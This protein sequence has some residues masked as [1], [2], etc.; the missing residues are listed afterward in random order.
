MKPK[1]HEMEHLIALCKEHY[2][3]NEDELNIVHNFE[4]TYSADRA[5]WWYTKESFACRMVNKAFLSLDTKLLYYFHFLF[6][7][8]KVT[9]ILRQLLGRMKGA[10]YE[11][12][13]FFK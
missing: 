12:N 5:I 13:P 1:A 4:E 6:V 8:I 3:G 11:R 10:N 7:N 9:K 2:Q